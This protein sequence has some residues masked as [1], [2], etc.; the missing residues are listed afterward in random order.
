MLKAMLQHYLTGWAG[1]MAWWIGT[2]AV[3]AEK[4]GLAPPTTSSSSQP[5]ITSV[6]GN[7]MT[8]FGLLGHGMRVA[9]MHSSRSHTSIC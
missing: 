4:P 8:S 5:G 3:P 2:P 9:H 1:V 6:P 7:L